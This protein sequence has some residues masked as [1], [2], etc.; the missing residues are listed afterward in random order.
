MKLVLLGDYHGKNRNKFK[1]CDVDIIDA[2]TGLHGFQGMTRLVR[3][4]VKEKTFSL[5]Q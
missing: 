2:L 1:I 3:F 5:K 4:F